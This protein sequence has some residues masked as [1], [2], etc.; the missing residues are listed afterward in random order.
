MSADKLRRRRFIYLML[1]WVFFSALGLWLLSSF[2]LL[3]AGAGVSPVAVSLGVTVLGG[4]GG[5]F[6]ARANG[7]DDSGG[8]EKGPP[9]AS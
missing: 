9:R 5:V 1:S 4:L 7:L 8:D 6:R 3:I 2:V